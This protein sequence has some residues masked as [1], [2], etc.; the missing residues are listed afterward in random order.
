MLD[1]V[2]VKRTHAI[3]ESILVTASTRRSLA[4]Q[5]LLDA[6]Q[7]WLDAHPDAPA[8]LLRLVAENRDPWPAPC[9]PRQRDADA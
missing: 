8:A 3:V 1:T 6:T 9:A 2:G 4:D 5:H 7:A